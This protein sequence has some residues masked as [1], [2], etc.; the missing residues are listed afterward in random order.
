M[1]SSQSEKHSK[2]LY[3]VVSAALGAGFSSIIFLW[4]T[5]SLAKGVFD[6][7]HFVLVVLVMYVA[8]RS[9]FDP[10]QELLTKPFIRGHEGDERAAIR[11]RS[12]RALL[13][14]IVLSLALGEHAIIDLLM[15]NPGSVLLEVLSSFFDSRASNVHL[16]S[17]RSS[18]TASCC[19]VER[20]GI[21]TEQRGDRRGSICLEHISTR[22]SH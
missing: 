15:K 11:P 5:W 3:V 12:V 14:G 2:E 4:L 21:W 20:S 8:S 18:E 7:L 22:S 19:L 6:W 16:D 9:F 17:G 10:L 13:L 1:K